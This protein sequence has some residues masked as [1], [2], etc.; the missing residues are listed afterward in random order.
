MTRT[1][2]L[3]PLIL[4]ASL[5]APAAGADLIEPWDRGF[6]DFELHF[7]LA[8]GGESIGATT[9]G[10]GLGG[11]V[12]AGLTLSGGDV[13]GAAGLVLAW[14]GTLGR[15]GDL[16]LLGYAQTE[17][18]DVEIDRVERAIGFEW[19]GRGV[20]WQP[21]LRA[22]LFWREEGRYF[23]PLV[24]VRTG[25]GPVDLHLEL[26]SAEPEPDEPWPVHLA[27]GPNF[28][29]LPGHEL[30]PELSLIWNRAAGRVEPAVTFT[31]ITSP[32]ALAGRAGGSRLAP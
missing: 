31:W 16:D 32:A 20:E 22:T 2:F 19:S 13:P 14:S 3:R 8:R 11:G 5:A 21:Y 15:Y 26:S 6:S 25:A 10:F 12:S 28:E 30:L 4:M 27:I 17:V 9:L 1:H 18:R 29:P 24:G 23:H 7:G